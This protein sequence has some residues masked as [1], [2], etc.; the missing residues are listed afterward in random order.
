MTG[1]SLFYFSDN[2]GFK[3]EGRIILY[4][5]FIDD[6]ILLPRK[7]VINKIDEAFSKQ[8]GIKFAVLIGE[9]GSGKTVISR[10]YLQ[11]KDFN[12]KAEIKAETLSSTIDSFKNLAIMLADTEE[13]QEKLSYI[14]AIRDQEPGIKQMISFVFS[15]LKKKGNWC[16]FFDN[17]DDFNVI[18]DFIPLNNYNNE[19]K[20]I[21]T[22][23]N[24]NF[25]N[26][27]A[28]AKASII[29]VPLLTIN[30]REDLF[31]KIVYE[32][33]NKNK[34][35]VSLGKFLQNIPSMP[36][37]VC[38]AAYYIKNTNVSFDEYL[39]I[40]QNP[41]V[42]SE[43]LYSAYLTEGIYSKGR[44]TILS[45]IFEKIIKANNDFKELLLVIFLIDSHNIPIRYLAQYKKPEI[46]QEIIHEL[47]RFSL[48]MEGEEFFSIHRTTQEMGLRYL[49]DTL[50]NSEK[51]E[52]I[53]NII[54]NITPYHKLIS[55]WR[56][57][58]TTNFSNYYPSIIQHLE[59][60]LEKIEICKISNEQLE[61]YKI[62][63]MLTM[64]CDYRIIL[65]TSKM[66][67]LID[68]TIRLN[69]KH[70]II[71]GYDLAF[72]LLKAV[73]LYTNLEEIEQVKEYMD[74]CLKVCST[75]R[76]SES[77]KAACLC[78]LARYYSRN[79]EIEKALN[80]L[81]NSASL[82]DNSSSNSDTTLALVANQYYRCI[83]NYFINKLQTYRAID[84][85]HAT[86]KK[87]KFSDLFYMIPKIDK[88]NIL[89]N[90][91][92]N[93]IDLI[94]LKMNLV[95][96]YNRVGEFE[97]AYKYMK[98]VEF[99]YEL[100]EHDRSKLPDQKAKLELEKGKIFL[101]LNKVK[102]GCK[103]FSKLLSIS[104]V[105]PFRLCFF[106]LV[107]R[108][109]CYIRLGRFEDAYKDCEA[110]R[111][112]NLGDNR[113]G[114]FGQLTMGICLYNMAISMYRMNDISLAKKHFE[115]FFMQMHKFCKSFF[116]KQ[117]VSKLEQQGVFMRDSTVM[118][119][120]DCLKNSMII[121]EKIYGSEHSFI[122]DYIS[123]NSVN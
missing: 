95:R 88:N 7:E 25:K 13:L 51:E 89:K 118:Q 109:E 29:E 33:K 63:I 67:E 72:L 66:K 99:L 54:K 34:E 77:I 87:L 38:A 114:N 104:S 39:K 79:F 36:L 40:T 11:L 47:R 69:K 1:S 59:S 52:F 28:F 94:E 112:I 19:G 53:N 76:N 48:I 44:Y 31:S 12:V 123:K 62:Q 101:R 121:F 68:E 30:E 93:Y 100:L 86:L 56:V 49:I 20:I 16:L 37:D 81:E 84:F 97:E 115:E 119:V 75:I 43:K 57:G 3:K 107:Y 60:V 105:Y 18:R 58:D 80:L 10:H 21:I 98:E 64:L 50:S 41:N 22:T 73:Y 74:K 65:S 35:S 117:T 5:Q 96:G 17:V 78:Y 26:I 32:G 91:R 70:K 2:I 14:G 111:K 23:R 106:A 103:I 116:D 108:S 9:G 83:S 6:D 55:A 45:S 42:N 27:S 8:N 113:G 71:I 4:K 92:I 15:L 24:G 110:A 90:K 82:I 122:K 102:K 46:V 120:P 61:K 85:L